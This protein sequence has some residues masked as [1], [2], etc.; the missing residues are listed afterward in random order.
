[1]RRTQGAQ[2]TLILAFPNFWLLDFVTFFYL[3]FLG[4]IYILRMR[5]DN[6]VI[7]CTQTLYK[8]MHTI[9]NVID[10]ITFVN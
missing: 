8:Y 5:G 7:N 2:A 1:M 4:V 3:S 9:R 10:M 6:H